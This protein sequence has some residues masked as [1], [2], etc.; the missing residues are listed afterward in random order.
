MNW[1]H[2]SPSHVVQPVFGNENDALSI[3]LT[4]AASV[5]HWESSVP[6]EAGRTYRFTAVADV[7]AKS[8]NN[9]TMLVTWCPA[10]NDSKMIQRD[11]IGFQDKN[12]LRCFDETFKAPEGSNFAIL[13]CVHKWQ[14]G[15]AVFRDIR[16]EEV[17]EIPPRRVRLA[18]VNIY[19][20]T[21]RTF[22][23]NLAIM[24]PLL[25]PSLMNIV[26]DNLKKG[27]NE[28]RIFELSKIYVPGE[29][30]EMPDERPHLGFAAFGDQEDF[31]TVKG[32]AEALAKALGLTFEVERAQDVPYLH[33]GIAAYLLCEGERIGC[34]G[35]LAN[36]V[37]AELKLHKD[38]KSNHKI[39]LGE[40]DY[41]KMM[42]HMAASFRY[43]PLSPFPPVF[44]DL[45][46]TVA[47]ETPCGDLMHEIARACPQVGDVELFDIYR[48]EQIGDGRKSMAFKIRFDPEDKALSP[49]EVDRFIKKILGN[50]RFKLGAEIR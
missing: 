34:F 15:K 35:K 47:E 2:I 42:S 46:L 44:R 4:D 3:E 40:I 37:T 1:K 20:K 21:E 11:Y 14:K 16:M 29:D 36:E 17:A 18:T 19:P 26:V 6:V 43:R 45:A 39:F 33:P 7:P 22:A 10:E 50:L 9:V 41:G 23:A 31:F 28:G 48:G 5:G 12:G 27:N 13:W 30:G 49:E 25:I 32:T 38:A 24:R 8:F